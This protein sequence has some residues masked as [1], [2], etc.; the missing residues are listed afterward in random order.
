[1]KQGI[2]L[3]VHKLYELISSVSSDKLGAIS[4]AVKEISQ[5]EIELK[6]N[7]PNGKTFSISA[8]KH[9]YFPNG[10]IKHR[11]DTFNIKC[12]VINSHLIENED[13]SFVW[14]NYEELLNNISKS[15]KSISEVEE[16]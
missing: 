13:G 15:L 7:F 10:D 8:I 11:A 4:W 1:M 16:E 3:E 6:V 2:V 5:D 14:T 9:G 12:G